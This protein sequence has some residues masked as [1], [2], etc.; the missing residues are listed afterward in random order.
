M[1]WLWFGGWL[2]AAGAAT[3][4]WPARRRATQTSRLPMHT[5]P[6]LGAPHPVRRAA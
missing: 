6:Q 5:I 3:A 2:A 4:A 1:R